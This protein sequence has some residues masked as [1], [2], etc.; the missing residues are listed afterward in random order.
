MN[1]QKENRSDLSMKS[2][3]QISMIWK[4]SQKDLILFSMRR[5]KETSFNLLITIHY[6]KYLCF[7]LDRLSSYPKDSSL[8]INNDM[9][10]ISILHWKNLFS[11]MT[12]QSSVC[13]ISSSYWLDL[14]T[15]DVWSNI[16]VCVCLMIFKYCITCTQLPCSSS[17]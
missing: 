7:S 8:Y 3:E 6:S 13:T 14:T 12:K 10:I 1:R 2:N 17:D 15:S 16:Y 4:D 9:M 11:E 5:K